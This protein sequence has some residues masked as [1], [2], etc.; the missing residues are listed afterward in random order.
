MQLAT[1]HHDDCCLERGGGR[2]R[3]D[4]FQKKMFINLGN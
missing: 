2:V 3:G 4:F 1:S